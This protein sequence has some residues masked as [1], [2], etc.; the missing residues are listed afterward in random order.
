MFLAQVIE[1]EVKLPACSHVSLLLSLVH[2][3]NRAT[4][5]SFDLFP[6][7]AELASVGYFRRT[8]WTMFS[9]YHFAWLKRFLSLYRNFLEK[10]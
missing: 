8:S 6:G 9:F 5:N 10:N 2:T 4:W 1:K 7:L 3:L